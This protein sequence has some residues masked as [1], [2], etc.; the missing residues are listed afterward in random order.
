MT[1]SYSSGWASTQGDQSTTQVA[2]EQAAGVGQSAA[3]AGGQVASTAVDQT[4]QVAAEAK[5]QVRDLAGEAKGHAKQQITQQHEKAVTGIRGIADSLTALA[6]GNVDQAP[7]VATDLA[8][9][10][11][12][13][14]KEIADWIE[15]REPGELVDEL[16]EL[17][18]RRPGAFLAGAAIAGVLAGRLTRGVVEAGKDESSDAQAQGF[19]A[20]ETTTV[21][22]Y[23]PPAY[24]SG[25]SYAATGSDLS[26]PTNAPSYGAA[27]TTGSGYGSA[28]TTYGESI[29][30]DQ[31]VSGQVRP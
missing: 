29:D 22:A 1:E 9:Q 16:R 20:T 13:K 27:G 23:E 24:S 30:L 6:S 18:R 19:V 2:K 14:V 3:Q 7:G 26:V 15:S 25:D 5:T 21:T 8:N 4:K 10:A 12:D 17:A 28:G 31:P 11:A